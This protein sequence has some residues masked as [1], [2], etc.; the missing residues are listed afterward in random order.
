MWVGGDGGTQLVLEVAKARDNLTRHKHSALEPGHRGSMG[1]GS[2]DRGWIF[3][4]SAK[5][6]DADAHVN[7]G[8][9][10]LPL[11]WQHTHTHIHTQTMTVCRSVL[12][13]GVERWI[14]IV[15]KRG[16]V[17]RVNCTTYK[18]GPAVNLVSSHFLLV[19]VFLRLYTPKQ[20]RSDPC[21]RSTNQ[22]RPKARRQTAA[23]AAAVPHCRGCLLSLNGSTKS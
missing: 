17:S 16:G 11:V 13:S 2:Q 15:R 3:Q 14:I 10:L 12:F 4:E 18:A 21:L 23:A 22:T 1:G 6:S 19:F 20:C 7:F 9:S 8:S 5:L